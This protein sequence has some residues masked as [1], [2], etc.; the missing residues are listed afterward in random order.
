MR[1]LLAALEG[2]LEGSVE[3]LGAK[4]NTVADAAERI[5]QQTDVGDRL[6][7]GV[8][9]V[10][11]A[12]ANAEAMLARIHRGLMNY[13]WLVATVL[14]VWTAAFA[15]VGM[16][17]ESEFGWASGLRPEIALR[18]QAWE[19]HGENIR[20]S[21]ADVRRWNE[22]RWYGIYASPPASPVRQ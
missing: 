5:R 14:T 11:Q 6:L 9:R 12:S 20:R 4:L 1:E 13:R 19:A 22:A 15:T 8:G 18:H 10:E 21:Y 16:V 7:Q 3:D 17:T 2:T